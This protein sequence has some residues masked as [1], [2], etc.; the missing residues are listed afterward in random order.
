MKQKRFFFTYHISGS[1]DLG[2]TESTERVVRVLVAALFQKPSRRLRAKPD[3]D[4]NWNGWGKCS[5]KLE[6]PGKLADSVEDKVGAE[7]DEDTESDPELEGHD[8]TAAN[9]GR[10]SLRGHDWDSGDLDT[11]TCASKRQSLRSPVERR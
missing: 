9:D 8:Q 6:A 11:H 3:E 1:H 2:V 5:S 7:A 10:N 4:E